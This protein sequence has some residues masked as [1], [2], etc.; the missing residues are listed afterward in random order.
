MTELLYQSDAYLQEFDGTITAVNGDLVTLDRTAFYPRGGGQP[1]D[2]A[3]LPVQHHGEL[4]ALDPA[5]D[6]AEGDLT[7]SGEVGLREEAVQGH[8]GAGGRVDVPVTH[9]LAERV[10]AI[11]PGCIVTASMNGTTVHISGSR[12]YSTGGETPASAAART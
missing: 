6:E 9:P 4:G 7:Q 3:H 5:G 10:R 8:L 11:N 1:S 2:L 12:L